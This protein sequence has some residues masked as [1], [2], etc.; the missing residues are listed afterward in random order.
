MSVQHEG[1]HEFLTVAFVLG[2]LPG[3]LVSNEV[4]CAQVLGTNKTYKQTFFTRGRYIY[5]QEDKL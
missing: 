4:L 5:V 2:C 1:Q 3:R